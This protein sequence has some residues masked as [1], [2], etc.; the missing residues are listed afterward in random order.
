[1]QLP[2][3]I[4]KRIPELINPDLSKIQLYRL[5]ESQ[6]IFGRSYLPISLAI[7]LR[8]RCRWSHVG[9]LLGDTVIEAR[10]GYGVVATPLSEF[11]KRYRE[12]CVR[13]IH[14]TNPNAVEEIKD[15]L[16]AKYDGSAFWGIAL[17]L[18]WDE[19]C[20]YQCAELIGKHS[21]LTF[22]KRYNRLVPKNIF[23]VSHAIS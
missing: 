2:N 11:K 15:K 17:G 16:G 8:T 23:E 10:G 5:P 20:A 13:G 9:L 6:L 4:K 7:Q 19:L 12:T 22:K 21:G 18:D 1:M 14:F 3:D